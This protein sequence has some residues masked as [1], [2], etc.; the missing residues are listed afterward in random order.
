MGSPKA[1]HRTIDARLLFFWVLV[2]QFE[3]FR[4]N[5]MAWGPCPL[6]LDGEFNKV[7]SIKRL[8]RFHHF[9][10]SFTGLLRICMGFP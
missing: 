7:R 10:P 1:R 5:S 4:K 8:V 9:K 2:F 6:R 3:F